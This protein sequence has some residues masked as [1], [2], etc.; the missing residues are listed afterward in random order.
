[1]QKRSGSAETSCYGAC[2]PTSA[3]SSSLPSK[4]LTELDVKYLGPLNR[5]CIAMP[6]D[7]YSGAVETN[8]TGHRT[9]LLLSSR[10][11]SEVNSQS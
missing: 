8:G 5:H 3:L 2:Y 6:L 1:M 9:L 11:L 4:I 10:L 7:V